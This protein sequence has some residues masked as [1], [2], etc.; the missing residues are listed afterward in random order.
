MLE[1]S[2]YFS[3]TAALIGLR[4]KSQEGTVNGILLL[5]NCRVEME[6]VSQGSR[7][8]SEYNYCDGVVYI[9]NSL[10]KYIILFK[11]DALNSTPL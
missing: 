5:L 1:L 8:L 11:T 7:N 9:V 4:F 6:F 2:K 10:Y 3:R